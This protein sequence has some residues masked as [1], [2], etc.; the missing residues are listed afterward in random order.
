[1]GG[2]M[3][4]R[5]IG[6]LGC[7][8]V[9]IISCYDN[10]SNNETAFKNPTKLESQHTIDQ[11][12]DKSYEINYYDDVKVSSYYDGI[13]TILSGNVFIPVSQEKDQVFPAIIFI[14]S[15]SFEEHEYFIQAMKF[16]RKGYIVLS[17]SCRGWW[18]SGGKIDMGGEEDWAD[19][20]AVVDWM[21]ANTPLD[22]DNIGV[23]G[24]SLGGGT[25]L[26]AISHD[27]RVKT[28]A[29]MS[30]YICPISS[31]FSDETP[32]LDW[33]KRLVKSGTIFGSMNKE[34]YEVFLNTLLNRNIDW[35]REW[36]N[37]RAPLTY[38]DFLNNY[39]KPI[40]LAHNYGDYMFRADVALNYFNRLKVD[41]KRLDLN[42]G[43]H[44]TGEGLA[45]FGIPTYSF[46]NM[47]R[48]FDYWLKG[49]D[50]GIIDNK[51]KSAVVTMAVKGKRKRVEYYTED[52]KKSIDDEDVYTWPARSIDDKVYYLKPRGFRITGGLSQGINNR[53]RRETIG[54]SFSSEASSGKSFIGPALE[55]FYIPV[56]NHILLM[57]RSKSIV[58][59]TPKLINEFSM[60]GNAKLDIR[61]S[62]NRKKGQVFFYLYD[63]DKLGCATFITHGFRT[64]WDAKP[65]KIMRVKINFVTIAYDLKKG[66][67]L[68]VVMDTSDDNYGKPT[69]LP[70]KVSV[71]YG[72][73][74]D[75]QSVLIIPND[76]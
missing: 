41:H 56:K 38:I 55:G 75:E 21:D 46:N 15:W 20:S 65:N 7:I 22:I 5:T 57:S 71:H 60:R 8:I 47:H 10:S 52:L 19:F 43:T 33:G 9:C 34:I 23:C 59:E 76:E 40:Y 63:V 66:H 64:F 31:M 3:L 1:M 39:N 30:S 29:A 27:S 32:R 48:W 54:S 2:C 24:M 61:L 45:I 14:N 50:T 62:L 26:Q 37:I 36:C 28:V 67:K 73:N 12:I 72:K 18:S 74:Y 42:V 16:A 11:T 53:N 25:A 69:F 4:I 35:V 70:F 58:Y 49:I 13:E 51:D 6:I 68:A 44:M 17:Y